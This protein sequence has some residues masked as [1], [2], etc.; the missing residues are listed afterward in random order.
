MSRETIALRLVGHEVLVGASA[1]EALELARTE[2]LDTFIP[3]IGLSG[4]D[5][6][7]LAKALRANSESPKQ[8]SSP[9]PATAWLRT[10][11]ERMKLASTTTSRP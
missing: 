6:Y 9:R 1:E 3:D 4:I 5:G 7:G 2:A 11:T 8:P 10:A